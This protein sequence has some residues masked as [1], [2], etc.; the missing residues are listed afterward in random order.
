MFRFPTIH[1]WQKFPNVLNKKERYFVI[2][3]VILIIVSAFGWIIAHKLTTTIVA[4]NFGGSFTEGIVGS[5]QY[6]NPIL[7]QASDSDRDVTEL[8]FSGLT[9]YNSKGE[10]VPNLAQEY[11]IGDNGK[12]YEFIL[13]NDIKWHDG[14][15]FTA[16]DVVF[17]INR[18]QNPDF[19]S[20]L[21]V[22]WSGVEIEKI[23][24]YKIKFKLKNA[25]APFL[26]NTA[27]GIIAKHIWEKITPA[28]FSLMPEN[29]EPI[30]TGPYKLTQIKKDKDGFVSYIKL[31]A[32]GDY[33]S[34]RRPF[35]NKINLNFYPDEITAIKAYNRGQIDNLSLIS[36]KNKSLI[37]GE[38]RS[39][40]EKLVLPRYFA[41]FFNQ[42]K[43]KALSDKVVRQA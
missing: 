40:I 10:I 23:D 6:I 29:L 11:K 34:E 8:I 5:P 2:V 21:R 14:E 26:A 36:I 22:S 15:K 43:S 20:P 32:F 42:S 35:I 31:E 17:T 37:K 27:T 41:V 24:D 4:P 28:N 38:N 25:Y 3:I 30:G 16:D 12:T 13:R 18:I 19:R 33:D 1:Q 39:N 9:K 7:S